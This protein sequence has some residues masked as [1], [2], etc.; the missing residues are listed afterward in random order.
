MARRLASS[1][2]SGFGTDLIRVV[3]DPDCGTGHHVFAD[4]AA[5]GP[6]GRALVEELIPYIEATVPRDPRAGGA[7]AQRPLVGRLEQSL[8]PGDLSRR[9][10]AASG[11]P[12][13]TRSISATSS[14][15][16]STPGREHVPRPRPD[17]PADRPPRDKRRSCSSTTSR[18]WRTCSATAASSTRSRPSSA[19]S[20]PT[21]VP[22]RS[23]TGPPAPSTPR[24]RTPGRLTTSASS[25]SANWA[26]LGPKLAGKLHVITG[27]LDTFYLEGA[28]RLL[29]AV[30]RRTSAATRSSRSSRARTTPRCSTRSSPRGSTAR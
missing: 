3:L 27:E 22:G 13:P 24:S 12:A 2:R 21:A 4:S 29:K 10:S 28:V 6:R 5:N 14:G 30:A 18:G 7:A 19:R 1:R 8:A 23:G 16:T 25:S 17:P 15:S 9:P 11:P 26:T 20:G